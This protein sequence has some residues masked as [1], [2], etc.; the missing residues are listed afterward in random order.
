MCQTVADKVRQLRND[1]TFAVCG[2]VCVCMCVCGRAITIVLL[3]Y[4]CV[5]LTDIHSGTLEYFL[6]EHIGK[7]SINIFWLLTKAV[8]LC[9]HGID[10]FL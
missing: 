8:K 6:D 2:P 10:C 9:Q 7:C 1:Q 4:S 3:I 5:S